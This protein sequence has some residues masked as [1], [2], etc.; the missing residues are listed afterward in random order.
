MLCVELLAVIIDNSY[1]VALEIYSI[2]TLLLKLFIL[3]IEIGT[4]FATKCTVLLVIVR[5]TVMCTQGL[6]PV[7]KSDFV[8][9]HNCITLNDFV[10]AVI[11]AK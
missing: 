1:R 4:S 6:K 3:V 9:C 8:M 10:V 5:Y 7:I 11:V 2:N